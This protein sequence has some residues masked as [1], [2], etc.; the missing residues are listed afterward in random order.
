MARINGEILTRLVNG[1]SVI[2]DDK[3]PDGRVTNT[4]I[5]YRFDGKYFVKIS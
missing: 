3:N 1:L 2:E 4:F 5:T